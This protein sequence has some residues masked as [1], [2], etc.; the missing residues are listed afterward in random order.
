[1]NQENTF[2]WK[3]KQI[4]KT[5]SII[6][7]MHFLSYHMN[8]LL[9]VKYLAKVEYNEYIHSMYRVINVSQPSINWDLDNLS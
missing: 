8:M 6:D 1:M 4:Y 5:S 7:R 3:I 2:K 9:L